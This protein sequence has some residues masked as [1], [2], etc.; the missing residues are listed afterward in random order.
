MTTVSGAGNGSGGD[1]PM[2]AGV[3]GRTPT[4]FTG[5]RWRFVRVLERN[6]TVMRRMWTIIL[7]GFFEPVF[8]LFS[9]GVGIGALVGKVTVDG[10]S[11]SYS[12]FVAP[13]LLAASAMNGA[14][15]ESTM[16]IFYKL[17]EANVYDGMLATPLVP[18]DIAVGEIVFSLMRGA[19]YAGGFLLVMLAMGLIHSWW[20][21]LLLPSSVLIGFAFA[22]TGMAFTCYIRSWQDLDLVQLVVLPLFLFSATFYPLSTYSPAMQAVVQVTPLFRG[23]DLL[24]GLSFGTVG[25]S[26]LIDVLYLAVMAVAGLAITSRRLHRLLL[27]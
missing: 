3:R 9:I 8:Y 1:R 26:T 24:R 12:A 11:V 7:S 14:I 2:T 13:A 21:L 17:K 4:L 25:A 20:G 5:P 18:G 23:V 10:R 22:A 6:L 27:P 16:N 19:I 15:Y